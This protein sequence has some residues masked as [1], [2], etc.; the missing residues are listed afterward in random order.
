MLVGMLFNL[1]AL[2]F[3]SKANASSL[4]NLKNYYTFL[5]W[6]DVYVKAVLDYAKKTL[7]KDNL[8]I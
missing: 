2:A 8:Q 3:V 5:E 1:E 4:R 6:S 7:S